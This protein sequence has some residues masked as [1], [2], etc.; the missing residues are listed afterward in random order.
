MSKNYLELK[1][2]PELFER[3]E[4][5]LPTFISAPVEEDFKDE[6]QINSQFEEEKQTV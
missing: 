4:N 5:L 3:K 1:Y 6:L 2:F